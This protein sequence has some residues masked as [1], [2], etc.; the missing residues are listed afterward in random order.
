MEFV[1]VVPRGKILPSAGLHGFLPLEPGELEAHYL[2]PARTE[3]FFVERRYAEVHPEFKQTIPYVVVTQGSRVLCLTRLDTQGER[4]LHGRR[5]IGVGGHVNPCD[6]EGPAPD[7]LQNA[8]LREL[9]EE[10]LL[11]GDLDPG[12][13]QPLGLLNDDTTEVGAVHLGLVFRLDA[14][15]L[16]VAIRETEAMTGRLE[17][18]DT[19]LALAEGPEPPFETWSTLLLRSGA[20]AQGPATASA[21][22]LPT[23]SSIPE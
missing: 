20:L 22:L 11:P 5:S 17:E 13:L 7:L 15:R 12:Q 23:S 21:R 1:W 19:L 3:G 16:T 4:R 14:T 8:C 6:T 10:L 18:L 2:A 9:H